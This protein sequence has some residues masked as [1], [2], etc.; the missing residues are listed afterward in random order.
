MK[1]V[2]RR[3]VKCA[4]TIGREIGILT[5]LDHPNICKMFETYVDRLNIHLVMEFIEGHDLQHEIDENIRLKQH[6]EVKYS[7]IVSQ[8]LDATFETSVNTAKY[9]FIHWMGEETPPLKRSKWNRQKEKAQAFVRTKCAIAISKTASTLDDLKLR[10][11]IGDLYR[12]TA[13]ESEGQDEERSV[14]AYLAAIA[15]E[16]RQREAKLMEMLRREEEEERQAALAAQRARDEE[17]MAEEEAAR[18]ATKPA[19]GAPVAP[20][21][22]QVKEAEPAADELPS[23]VAA[24]LEVRNACGMWDWVLLAPMT[25]GK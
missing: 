9:Y 17:R 23:A 16:Q 22:E 10:P 24:I 18:Q 25:P 5:T 19:E 7:V 15:E 4:K 13:V 20:D 12:F 14:E 6:D 11:M 8:I 21:A 1:Q 2:E 3:R